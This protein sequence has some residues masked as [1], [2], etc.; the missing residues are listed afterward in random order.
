MMQKIDPADYQK[1]LDRITELF[2][3]F[4]VHAQKQSMSR[5]P[6]RNRLDE[7]TAKFEC[8]NQTSPTEKSA[9]PV[10]SGL[11]D[12]CSAWSKDSDR[13]DDSGPATCRP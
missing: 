10:C 12:Y 3:G 11:I 13:G 5:C 7:C 4:V 8:R 9:L 6:Y 2:S 1:R